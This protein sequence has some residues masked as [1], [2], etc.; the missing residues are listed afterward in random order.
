MEKEPQHTALLRHLEGQ[1][2]RPEVRRS[3]DQ[4]GALLAEEFVEFGSS[5]R[6]FDKRRIIEA[7]QQE[8]ELP[9]DRPPATLKD[10][11]ARE[12]ASDVVLVTYR[13]VR[14]ASEQS[15]EAST[16][17]SSIWKSIGGKWQRSIRASSNARSYKSPN[18][19]HCRIS[20]F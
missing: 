20:T 16:L 18:A 8:Q 14:A 6:V 9:T 17:R 5:G 13:I 10:F 2:L 19:I 12:L 4:V 1:L 11:S 15:E 3:V 7:L